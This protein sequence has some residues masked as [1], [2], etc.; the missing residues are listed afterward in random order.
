MECYRD[1]N[2]QVYTL[3]NPVPPHSDVYTHSLLGYFFEIGKLIGLKLLKGEHNHL[4]YE[5]GKT[6][7]V[8]NKLTPSCLSGDSESSYYMYL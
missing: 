2:K 5:N 7:L 8:S 3:K 1:K 6:S 4:S